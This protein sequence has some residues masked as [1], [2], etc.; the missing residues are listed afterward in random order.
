MRQ[1]YIVED[2]APV[3]ASLEALLQSWGYS[4]VTFP[5]GEA[6]LSH[7]GPSP[8][9]VLVDVRLPG[10]DG[11]EVLDAFREKDGQT[12][13]I[14]MTGHGQISMAVDAMQRGAQDFLEKPF[15]GDDLVARINAAIDQAEPILQCREKLNRLTPRETEVLR[16]I[17]AGHQNKIIAHNLG[18]SQK[19]AEVHRAR[20]MSKTEAKSVPQL[21]RIALAGGISVDDTT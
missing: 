6:F 5:T 17:V 16:E 12:P 4:C 20:V 3:A 10:M 15:D 9:C 7:P 18:I 21:I 13:I 2:D 19:T 1:V 8:A 14:V 11:L